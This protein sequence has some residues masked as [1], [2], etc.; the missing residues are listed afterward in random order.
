MNILVSIIV[1][2]YNVE[3]YLCNCLDSII[4]QTYRN[5]DI[6]LV[7]DGSNDGSGNLCD[8]YSKI[9]TRIRV[10][11][12]KNEGVASARISGFEHSIGDLITFIDADDYVDSHFIEKLST[13]FSF[14]D[15]DLC[16][17]NDVTDNNGKL[18]SPRRSIFGLKSREQIDAMLKTQYLFDKNLNHAGL[19][20]YLCTKLIKRRYVKDALVCGN[21]LLWGE[22]Q[23]ASFYLL[24]H[25]RSM[26][27]L[28]EGLYY[29]VQ[30]DGQVT[31]RY[32]A[33]IWL[34]QFE[35]WERYRI[36]DSKNLL[37]DQLPL[38]MWWT[39]KRNFKKMKNLAWLDF[40][41]V[42]K[43]IDNRPIWKL[44]LKNDSL[45]QGKREKLA[46]FLLRYKYYYLFYHI[47]LNRL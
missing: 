16:T 10:I 23:I 40:S 1:P 36:L 27:S 37:K 17:C 38:R 43:D 26:F 29:Y 5:L 31:K 4:N 18:H 44:F 21:G 13:P 24:T 32:D 22:D 45:A 30:H 28:S 6:V 7:D 35:S 46:F 47:L 34:N 20:V 8:Y 15:I 9:D 42:M 11:H 14:Y 3:K 33:R 12:K 25:V 19:P 41:N 39:I 2:V